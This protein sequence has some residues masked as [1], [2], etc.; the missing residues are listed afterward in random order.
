MELAVVRLISTVVLCSLAGSAFE[1]L[2]AQGGDSTVIRVQRLVNAGDR[3]GARRLADSVLVLATDGSPAYAEALFARAFAS[4]AVEAERDYLRVSFE[5]SLSARAEDATMMVAQ[6]KL[7]RSDRVG[8]RRNFERLVREHPA[9]AQA[10][11][12]AF[13]AGRLALEDGDAAAGCPSLGRARSSVSRDDV[14]LANQIDYYAQRCSASALAG[15]LP[16]PAVA[17]STATPPPVATQATGKSPLRPTPKAVIRDPVPA[18]SPEPPRA[19][20][21]ATQPATERATTPTAAPK[22]ASPP[23]PIKEFSVQVAAFPKVRDAVALAEVLQQRGFQVRVWGSKAPFRVREGRYS[24]RA[25]AEAARTRMKASRV[26]GIVVEA[27]A[28]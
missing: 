25:D 12:A 9:G 5:Y 2:E 22:A 10:A 27:E 16:Q 19:P 14:E 17:E 24:S 7:A 26:N 15:V 6:L 28:M 20:E 11:K 8:A 21:P 1:S 3:A 13:W 23:A 18:R 4:S